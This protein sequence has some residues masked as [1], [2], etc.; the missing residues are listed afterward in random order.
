MGIASIFLYK[1]TAYE[2]KISDNGNI[3]VIPAVGNR[4]GAEFHLYHVVWPIAS[5]CTGF[6]LM[7]LLSKPKANREQ[8]QQSQKETI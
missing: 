3:R 1:Y 8:E 2:G 6:W 7:S 4:S 5:L